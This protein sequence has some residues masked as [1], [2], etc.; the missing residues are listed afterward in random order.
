MLERAIVVC[1]VVGDTAA[2]AAPG[3]D[4]KQNYKPKQV[5]LKE[6]NICSADKYSCLRALARLPNLSISG[7][8]ERREMINRRRRRRPIDI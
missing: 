8:L 6:V 3:L 1:V 5:F 7:D 4:D 2:A